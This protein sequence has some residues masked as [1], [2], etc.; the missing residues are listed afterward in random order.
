MTVTG[1][2]L[3]RPV[4]ADAERTRARIITAAMRCVAEA[5]HTRATIREIARGAGMTSASLY[6]YFANKCELL[7]A[8]VSEMDAITRLEA[9]LE[10]SGRLMRE[11]PDIAAFEWVIRAENAIDVDATAPGGFQAF[12]EII[13]GIVED[14]FREGGL[15]GRA[16]RRSRGTAMSVRAATAAFISSDLFGK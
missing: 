10:E 8:T 4:G 12:R 14:A 2:Q 13:D 15:A 3:G 9:V 11:Y 16:D 1:P 5:G 6:H 7:E